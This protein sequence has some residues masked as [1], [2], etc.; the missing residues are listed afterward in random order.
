MPRRPPGAIG[1]IHSS[2][3]V[4]PAFVQPGEGDEQMMEGPETPQHPGGG[5]GIHRCCRCSRR[6]SSAS[7]SSATQRRTPHGTSRS[8]SGVLLI[9]PTSELTEGV[10]VQRRKTA[11]RG[12]DALPPLPDLL[13]D[14]SR[15]GRHN[16]GQ[17][18]GQR[19]R[20][21]QPTPIGSPIFG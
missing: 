15:S 16:G 9:L 8:P 6:Y 3:P 17:R 4:A 5:R 2:L 10:G 21:G 11:D 18:I 19:R 7:A 13:P 14:A 1:G 20:I 12:P